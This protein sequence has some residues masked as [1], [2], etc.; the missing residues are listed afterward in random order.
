MAFPGLYIDEDSCD[1]R[2]I[3]ALRRAG[4]DVVTADEAG[5]RGWSD[6]EQLEFAASLGRVIL[7][8]NVG[9]F[10]GLQ[11]SWG[12]MHR[13]HFGIVIWK[14]PRWSP[15][16]FAEHFAGVVEGLSGTLENAILYF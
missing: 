11:R 4:F 10:A 13:H 14:R 1:V 2:L 6:R 15:E 3:A 9:D 12:R 5:T 16:R 8:A 7:S